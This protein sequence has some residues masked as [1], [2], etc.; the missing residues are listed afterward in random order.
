VI[1]GE[2]A[3]YGRSSGGGINLVTKSGTKQLARHLR[4]YNR[5]LSL[6]LTTGLTIAAACRRC[7]LIRQPFG[8]NFGGL[9]R[10]TKLFFFFDYEGLR[11]SSGSQIIRAVPRHNFGRRIGYI[12]SNAGCDGTARFASQPT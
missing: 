5:I 7:A 11:R 4:E 3:D 1:A 12:N 9:S 8:G 6:P 10:R 2:T